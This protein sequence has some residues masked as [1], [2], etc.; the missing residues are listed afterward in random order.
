MAASVVTLIPGTA[1][2]SDNTKLGLC[3]TGLDTLNKISLYRRGT[4]EWAS[5]SGMSE[6]VLNPR[7]YS[8]SAGNIEAYI[9]GGG[10]D[11]RIVTLQVWASTCI[12][13]AS[14]SWYWSSNYEKSVPLAPNHRRLGSGLYQTDYTLCLRGLDLPPRNFVSNTT[15]GSRGY[16]WAHLRGLEPVDDYEIEKFV[17]RLDFHKVNEWGYLQW[18]DGNIKREGSYRVTSTTTA[19]LASLAGWR[20]FNDSYKGVWGWGVD[21][22]KT[23]LKF[24]TM[25]TLALRPTTLSRVSASVFVP[26]LWQSIGIGLDASVETTGSM[27]DRMRG[28]SLAAQ[29][30][31]GSFLS[32]L[33]R[34]LSLHLPTRSDGVTSTTSMAQLVEQANR[35]EAASIESFHGAIPSPLPSSNPEVIPKTGTSQNSAPQS[36]EDQVTINRAIPPT[37]KI[38][39]D[40]AGGVTLDQVARTDVN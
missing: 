28:F 26:G 39:T 40:G 3:A 16:G 21:Y 2:G 12:G 17:S 38:G 14:L 1:L 20:G 10:N 36:M 18:P 4:E 23:D 29:P 11:S 24:E 15:I 27:I 8:R 22:M 19:G 13:G 6:Y 25:A 9:T 5:A 32:Q 35:T 30:P 37:H 34:V 33:E 7:L 31:D